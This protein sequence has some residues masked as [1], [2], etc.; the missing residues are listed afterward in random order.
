[1]RLFCW[2]VSIAEYPV[3]EIALFTEICALYFCF[4]DKVLAIN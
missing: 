1:M 3:Y 4:F 2:V